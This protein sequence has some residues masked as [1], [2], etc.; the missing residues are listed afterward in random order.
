MGAEQ[1]LV[2]TNFSASVEKVSVLLSFVDEDEKQSPKMKAD[3]S[4]TAIHLHHMCAQFVNLDLVLQVIVTRILFLFLDYSTLMSSLPTNHNLSKRYV[5]FT[6]LRFKIMQVSQVHP[7]EMNFEL[8]VQHIQLVDHLSFVND[9]GDY[10]IHVQHGNSESETGLIKKL[11]DDVQGSLRTARESTKD[12]GVGHQLN[13][14]VEVPL[15]IPD[16][17]GCQHMKNGK[18][19]C[20]NYANVTL[21]RTSGVSSCHVS[22]NLSSSDSSL[23]GPTSFTLKLPP[24]VCW[25][26]FDLII[27]MLEFLQEM[28]NCIGTTSL[29]NG[30]A[31]DPKSKDYGFSAIRDQGKFSHPRSTNVSTRKFL[32][33]NIFLP[34]ARI[35]LCFP[36][37]ERKY[38]SS[39][40][41]CNQFVA[42]DLVSPTIRG[43]DDRSTSL[44]PVARF[45]KRPTMTTSCS[46]NLN[47]GDFYLF[48]ISSAF[49]EKIDGSKTYEKQE[50]SFIAEKIL[51]VVNGTGYLSVISMFWQDGP[52]TGPWIAKKAKLLASSEYG[53][54]QDKVVG[55]DSE[56]ASV[57]T[58][59][60]SNRFDTHTRQEMLASSAFFLRGKLPPATIYLDERKYENISGILN[61]MAE[62]F[63]FVTTE[64][65]SNMKEHSAL[66][67]SI[68]FECESVTISLAVEPVGF[69]KCSIRSELPSSWSSLT[70]KVDKFEILSVSNIGGIS[71]AKFL[72]VSHGKGSLW[73]STEGIN[74]EFL[75]ISCSD[76]T[77]GRGDGEGS[78]VLSSRYSGSDII[79]FSDPESNHIFTSITIRCATIVAIG[80]R[81]DW[82]NTIISFFILPSSESQQAGDNCQEKTFGS[83]FILNLVDVGLSYEPYIEKLTVNHGSDLKSS[84]FRANE[85]EDELYIACLLAASSL[86]LSNTT[87]TGCEERDYKIRLQDL[88][89]LICTV[90]ESGLVGCTHSVEQ[91]GN[92]GYVKIAQEANVE[93][94]LRTNCENGRAWELECA[95]S[96]ILLNTCHD[97]TVGLIR[98]AAQLQ[99]LFAPD[100]QDYVVHL[101]KR[102]NNVQ[103][104]H[105][106]DDEMTIGGE[107]YPLHHSE[108]SSHE[109]KS[110]MGN[111]MDEICEDV[112]QLDGNTVG[113]AK[114]FKSHLCSVVDDT[115][116]VARGASSS[117]EKSPEIIEEYF[118]SDLRPL[119]VLSSSGSQSSDFNGFNTVVVGEDRIGNDGWYGGTALR[120]LE[121]HASKVEK[122][123]LQKPVNF[124]VSTD[125]PEHVDVA[126]AEGRIVLKNINVSWRMYG[127]SDW[128]NFE[129]T[130]PTLA[131]ARDV[132]ASLE[133][134]LSG[135]CVE[136]DVYPD[137]E[138]SASTL[139]LTI[140]D[141]CLNDRSNDAPWKLVLLNYLC[142]SPLVEFCYLLFSDMQC[143]FYCKVLGN[144][145]SKKN[146]RK[147][148]SNAVKLNLEAVRPDPSI[149]IEENRCAVLAFLL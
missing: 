112:F 109:K 89:F 10:K 29:G 88:G 18:D 47:L 13:D 23:M 69:F 82:F 145:Q 39:Y 93:A 66:Q 54:S 6:P 126:I 77:M 128:S 20:Q 51:S 59:R 17:S 115:S 124:E 130:S 127:G 36:L 67:T 141:F 33:G 147:F 70:L 56:F 41:S 131:S 99:N 28:S 96:H 132:T 97:T 74:R 22:L 148:S 32:E 120:I 8:I 48:Y 1:Q 65:V 85:C 34:N 63:A 78:N 110:K 108:S 11:Q 92:L 45:D 72:W 2:E 144:Y 24:F 111:L 106:V 87:V 53:K 71:H 52:V 55:K 129:N 105:E 135:I 14:P 114:T 44:T 12:L 35:I 4:N 64:S 75:L 107:F 140:R 15:N 16:T 42:F 116:L 83:S 50:A 26:H 46:L 73:G 3:M 84:D 7:R 118:L 58:V 49:L 79:N 27:T 31:P 149:R 76:S 102:W 101:E 57:T 143:V 122:P 119:S 86:K 100:M 68:L 90:P 91:L 137:G 60:D 40:S 95:E 113:Q 138:I 121:N 139:S 142:F 133:L 134:A 30:F 61:Q 103:Q 38:Y 146:P 123:D 43:K 98:L 25:V 136:Y 80:G 5:Q 62:H 19:I 94:L 21:L 117:G 125:D 81:L 37:K 104:A 9:L